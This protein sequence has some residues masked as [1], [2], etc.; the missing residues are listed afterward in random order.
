MTKLRDVLYNQCKTNSHNNFLFC[1]GITTTFI[2]VRHFSS[3][4][5]TKASTE[6]KTQ[7]YI[8]SVKIL[9]CHVASLEN[10]GAT[11]SYQVHLQLHPCFG[12][13]NMGEIRISIPS[14]KLGF[15]YPVCKMRLQFHSTVM[16]LSFR[17]DRP[18]Q[19]M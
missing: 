11:K 8:C 10:I 7:I 6:I 3:I 19:T 9:M 17:T 1:R 5:C 4:R 12:C 2:L 14:E 18:G 16:I 13:D 15:A